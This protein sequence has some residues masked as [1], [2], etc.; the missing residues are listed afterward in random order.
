MGC[1]VEDGRSWTSGNEGKHRQ[2]A[3]RGTAARSSVV[4]Y[5]WDPASRT[6]PSSSSDVDQ[7]RSWELRSSRT[8]G[9]TQIWV[10][11]TLERTTAWRSNSWRL[12]SK[13]FGRA[14]GRQVAR[15]VSG[16]IRFR[17]VPSVISPMSRGTSELKTW[18][19]IRSP[20]RYAAGRIQEHLVPD[21]DAREQHQRPDRGA[22]KML[23][24]D[25]GEAL[26]NS[27]LREGGR[28]FVQ[29][30]F[31]AGG[32]ASCAVGFTGCVT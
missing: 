6:G 20:H 12:T 28:V 22:I 27:K 24:S 30:P 15:D 8:R 32:G 3:A 19:R 9:Q 11:R 21:G 25:V 18:A 26:W 16:R 29:L 1:G 14:G 13:M 2:C 4:A 17:G 31:E 23:F 7:R 5:S 10:R